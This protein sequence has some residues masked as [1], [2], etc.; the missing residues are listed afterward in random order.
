MKTRTEHD[1]L[2]TI[3]VA[4]D[5]SWGAQTQRSLNNFQIS[6]ETM[7]IE[8]IQAITTIKM[9]AAIINLKLKRVDANI[10]N[11][12]VKVSRDILNNKYDDQF[13]LSI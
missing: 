9:C 11:A 1:S 7:P 10:A 3:Q 13:P 2:G 5:K 12:I 6:N 8:L 4:D